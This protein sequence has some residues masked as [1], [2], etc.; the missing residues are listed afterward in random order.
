ML[1]LL[2]GAAAGCSHRETLPETTATPTYRQEDLL[3]AAAQAGHRNLDDRVAVLESQMKAMRIEVGRVSGI[4]QRLEARQLQTVGVTPEPKSKA[5][6]PLGKPPQKEAGHKVTKSG[7]KPA[8][9]ASAPVDPRDPWAAP[10]PEA[11]HASDSKPPPKDE[12]PKD[13]KLA[14]AAPEPAPETPAHAPAA[15]AAAPAAA[16]EAAGFGLQLAAFGSAARAASGWEELKSRGGPLLADL[17]PKREEVSQGGKT[18][19]RL[20]AGPLPDREAAT[21]RCDA[22]KGQN[23]PCLVTVFSGDWPSS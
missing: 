16:P 3:E 2:L 23:I 7:E 21:K 20:K 4:T 13:E 15:A 10:A 8:E 17:L 19:F 12:K 18:L 11:A 6:T 1:V 22:L 9:A 14:S 5:A